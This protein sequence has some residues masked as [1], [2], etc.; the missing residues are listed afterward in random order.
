MFKHDDVW[1]GNHYQVQDGLKEIMNLLDPYSD[2][3]HSRSN[4]SLC[5]LGG[6]VGCATCAFVLIMLGKDMEPWTER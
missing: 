6:R 2:A 1:H 5:R 4:P 3:A